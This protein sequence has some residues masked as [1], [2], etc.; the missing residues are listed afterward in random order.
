MSKLCGNLIVFDD[1]DGTLSLAHHTVQTFLQSPRETHLLAEFNM[2]ACKADH[3][4]GE[5]CITYLAFT[6]FQKSLTTT[7]DSRNLQ[8]LDRPVL[9]AAH[10]LTG[11]TFL[12]LQNWNER[13]RRRTGSRNFDVENQ[14]RIIRSII[15]SPTINSCFQLL[16]YCRT[17]WYHHCQAFPLED[18]KSVYSLKRLLKQPSLPFL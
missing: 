9:L 5:M 4:L 18:T 14:L 12:R 3:Y 10:M 1:F 16:E 15:N 6:D 7:G 2:Q 13:F 8:S 11:P 17:S